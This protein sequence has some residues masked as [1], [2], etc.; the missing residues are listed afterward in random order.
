MKNILKTCLFG[1]LLV[2]AGI[3][4]YAAEVRTDF[5]KHA[6]FSRITAIAG[7]RFRLRI[8]YMSRAS[9]TR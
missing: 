7:D 4:A 1:G 8:R 9:R 5:D 3:A 6:D 2:S